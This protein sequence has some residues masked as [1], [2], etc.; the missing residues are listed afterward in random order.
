MQALVSINSIPVERVKS[1]RKLQS[2]RRLLIKYKTTRKLSVNDA[3]YIA[4]LI[5]GE[6]TIT[7]Q[8]KHKNENR[9]LAV[10][11]SSTEIQLLEFV[12]ATTG[13]GIITTKRK[14]KPHHAQSFTY[15]VYSRQALSLLTQV[16]DYLLSYKK[17]RSKLILDQYLNVTPRNGKYSEH[18]KE[19][20][21]A[22]ENALLGIKPEVSEP[23]PLYLHG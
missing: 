1:L 8:R 18:Q 16:S 22:F 11:I 14:Y 21:A 10:T 15:A 5:D 4:G 20:R 7:L 19:S 2:L 23:R 12:K 13:V 6:G 9:R 3:A 17:L